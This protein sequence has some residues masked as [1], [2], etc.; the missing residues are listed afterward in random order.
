MKLN[1]L[2]EPLNESIVS[3]VKGIYNDVKRALKDLSSYGL[4]DYQEKNKKAI[5]GFAQDYLKRLAKGEHMTVDGLLKDI[6]AFKKRDKSLQ[7]TESILSEAEKNVANQVIK[8]LCK[9]FLALVSFLQSRQIM[10]T[11]QRM[12]TDDPSKLHGLATS[13]IF[14]CLGAIIAGLLLASAVLTHVGLEVEED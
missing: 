4:K 2:R 13:S 12:V 10:T 1:E 8:T 6:E 11:V 14:L 3:T 7:I 5:D 9:A